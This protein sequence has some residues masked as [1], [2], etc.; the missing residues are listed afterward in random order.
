V[1]AACAQGKC[2]GAF[3]ACAAP[4]E[5]VEGYCAGHGVSCCAVAP[6]PQTLTIH[7]VPAFVPPFSP[8]NRWT[9]PAMTP[10]EEFDFEYPLASRVAAARARRGL[11]DEVWHARTAASVN[12][13][14]AAA[15]SL[16][17]S[18]HDQGE[19]PFPDAFGVL[20]KVPTLQATQQQQQQQQQQQTRRRR[21]HILQS[22][23]I[24][25]SAA[26]AAKRGHCGHTTAC[27]GSVVRGICPGSN[28]I[29]CCV[30]ST[31]G[32][33]TT[34]SHPS[35]PSSP[36][37]PSGGGSCLNARAINMIKGFEV[38]GPCRCAL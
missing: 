27:R 30:P 19:E 24:V 5:R 2:V 6:K 25:N 3:D 32:H 7:V 38:R 35:T 31:G 20:P 33:T 36:S 34:P 12:A 28:A 18:V 13:A 16:S 9:T 8:W 15:S 14:K 22:T 1:C 11:Y 23:A 37:G 10:E 21:P 17:P 29:T 4:A 26:C